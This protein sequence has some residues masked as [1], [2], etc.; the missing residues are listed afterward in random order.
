MSE[1]TKRDL[2]YMTGRITQI[3]NE[4]QTVQERNMRLSEVFK[5]KLGNLK[6]KSLSEIIELHS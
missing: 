1:S 4:M 6:D 3:N 5:M 2:D